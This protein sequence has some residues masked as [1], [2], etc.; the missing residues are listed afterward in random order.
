M[1]KNIEEQGVKEGKKENK[2][3][4]EKRRKRITEV[5]QRI[6]TIRK[7]LVIMLI[8]LLVIYFVLRVVY[9]TGRFTVVLDNASN[10]KGAL[11]MYEKKDEKYTRKTLYADSKDFIT[12][13]SGDWIP[14]NIYDEADGAHNG[15]NY[16]AYTF[17]LENEGDERIHYW[18]R[19]VSDD[20]IR[21]VDKAIRV[22]VYIN[23]KKEV[24]AKAN[25]K[26][27]KPEEGTVAFREDEDNGIVL[28]KRADF[29][30][31]DIDK[32]TVVIWVEGD[33]PDC[34]DDLI[35]GEMKM[36]MVITEEHI[37]QD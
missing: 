11:V 18:Y 15:D 16:I 2:K 22:A 8:F 33:D 3:K 7:I 20:V 37:K 28:Q 13:I 36:H 25:S 27:S 5:N 31:H 10:M 32:I 4:R 14:E 26:T 24:Y 19:I 35:G 9:Q 1:K 17:Y 12:N 34:I 23:D 21:N 29:N 30:S 6:R